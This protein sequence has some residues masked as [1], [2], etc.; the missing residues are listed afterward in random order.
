[1][2]AIKNNLWK[3]FFSTF[4][5]LIFSSCTSEEKKNSNLPEEIDYIILSN[6]GGKSG[7]YRIIKIKK[8]S[9][10]LEKGAAAKQNHQEKGL[11]ISHATWKKLVSTVDIKNLD[12]IESSPSKQSVDGIDET[13]QIKTTKKSHV[14][15][16]AYNDSIHY[17]QLQN[18]KTEL[19]KILPKEYK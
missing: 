10:H 11:A 2:S 4:L 9:I 15:V 12:L 19:E 17:K 16:N 7:N 18:M 3:I 8:D 13:F 14:Y 5:L 6:V 1:M